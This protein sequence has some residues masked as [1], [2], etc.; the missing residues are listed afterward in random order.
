[1]LP[2]G[3]RG[4]G[5]SRRPVRDAFAVIDCARFTVLSD[6]VQPSFTAA[7]SI[8]AGVKKAAPNKKITSFFKKSESTVATTTKDDSPPAPKKQK[9]NP[10]E[11][12]AS[13]PA[14]VSA[15]ATSTPGDPQRFTDSEYESDGDAEVLPALSTALQPFKESTTH[16]CPYKRLGRCSHRIGY[17]VSFRSLAQHVRAS[18]AADD[19]VLSYDK[20]QLADGTLKIPCPNA[21]CKEM[22]VSHQKANHHAKSSTTC[23]P[24]SVLHC[25]WGPYNLCQKSFS[26]PRELAHHSAK[27]SNDL[28]SPYQ[29]SHG[30][31]LHH[32][33]L[34]KLAHHEERCKGKSVATRSASY[35]FALNEAAKNGGPPAIIVVNRS[36]S[37]PPKAWEDGTGDTMQGL[38]QIGERVVAH[39]AAMDGP[40][41]GAAVLHNCSNCK[42]RFLPAPAINRS[43]EESV[44]TLRLALHRAFEFT[45][46]IQSDIEAANLAGITP[47][48][49]SI[50]LDAWASDCK[51][52]LEWLRA[53]KVRFHLVLQLNGLYYGMS[54]KF[55]KLSSKVYWGSYDSDAIC[56]ALENGPGQDAKVDELIAAWK[57]LQDTKNNTFRVSISRNTLAM[58][59]DAPTKG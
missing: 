53:T 19:L 38:P 36:S 33:D 51:M 32:A 1:M 18:H 29:C 44:L 7:D 17:F 8:M 12:P 47:T 5:A 30:C 14:A 40:Q 3:R 22:F 25:P 11:R 59:D 46:A 54:E 6:I 58:S 55:L 10:A 28:S 16:P 57:T 34:Y 31:G 15:V 21:G 37:H 48:L 43:K 50:G 9:H 4:R 56:R 52:I 39:Y 49:I 27:H 26:S 42:T 13:G 2:H 35:R 24:P 41:V 23:N 45:K 20:C